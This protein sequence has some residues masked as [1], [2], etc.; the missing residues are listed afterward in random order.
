M[1]RKLIQI[2]LIAAAACGVCV[3]A[4]APATQPPATQP[5]ATVNEEQRTAI[6]EL[7]TAMNFKKTMSQMSSAMSQAMPQMLDQTLDS[8]AK[9]NPQMTPQKKE[10]MHKLAL[11]SRAKVQQE[12]ADMYSDPLVVRSLEDAMGRAYAKRF[13][14]PEI[15]KIT[16]FYNSAEGQKML[17]YL[18]EIMRESMPEIMQ[19]LSPRMTKMIEKTAKEVAARVESEPA[20]ATA[21]PAAPK[22]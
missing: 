1:I 5:P 20:A 2:G 12:L 19:T 11:E 10:A 13:S 6:N 17:N 16:A 3:F 9:T 14:T 22:K 18:P 7:L 4:Q 15:R 8:I 21:T